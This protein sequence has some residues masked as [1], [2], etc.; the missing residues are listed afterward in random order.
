MHDRPGRRLLRPAE[1]GG[2]RAEA[3]ADWENH[4]ALPQQPSSHVPLSL[5]PQ[6]QVTEI[7][8]RQFDDWASRFN[9]TFDLITVSYQGRLPA[10][11]C[12]YKETTKSW[13]LG[14]VAPCSTAG[15]GQTFHLAHST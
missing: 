15:T 1:A 3:R 6:A 5:V 7:Q 9:F 10:L 13:D 8:K 2:S 14:Q 12:T 4:I 11:L